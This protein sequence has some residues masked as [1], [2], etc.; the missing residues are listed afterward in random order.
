MKRLDSRPFRLGFSSFVLFTSLAGDFW[1]NWL[2]WYSFAAIVVAVAI[3][4]LLVILHHRRDFDM[5]GLPYSLLGFLALAALSLVWS[6]YQLSSALGIAAQLI[7]TAAAVAVAVLLSRDDLLAVLSWVL[8]TILA[9]SYTFEF[10]VAAF[11]R[12]PVLPVWADPKDWEPI[13]KVLYWSRALLFD[14]A[15][16]QGIVGNSSLLAMI[17]LL[18]VIVCSIQLGARRVGPVRGWLWIAVALVTLGITRS[19]TVYVALFVVIVVAGIA[20]LARTAR[21]PKLRAIVYGAIATGLVA[22]ISFVALCN[23]SLLRL[24][25]KSSDLTGRSGIWDAVVGLAQQRPAFG[26]GWVSYWTPWVEPFSGLVVRNGVQVTHAHNAWL[27]VWL[28]V[29]IVGVV[30]FALLVAGALMR[31]WLIALDADR[32]THAWTAALPLL[33]LTAQAVQSLSESRLLVEGGWVLLVLMAC[34]T[35]WSMLRSGAP[36]SFVRPA[37]AV[38]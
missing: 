4:S 15:K 22:L 3:V 23:S 2:G 12:H 6:S 19:A 17:A 16:I 18:A 32:D 13:P 21:T 35:K 5:R 20:A 26:W 27:D 38:P 10:V 30:L 37:A 1:R 9:L 24:L 31:S 34:T 36:T 33:V 7:T 25:G 14:G 8:R 29:G 11:V 28:Q